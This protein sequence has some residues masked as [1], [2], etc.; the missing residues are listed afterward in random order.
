MNYLVGGPSGYL[1]PLG[2][3]KNQSQTKPNQTQRLGAERGG[4]KLRR[5]SALSFPLQRRGEVLGD[6]GLTLVQLS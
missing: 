6:E 5:Y 1:D 4:G 2:P 3:K